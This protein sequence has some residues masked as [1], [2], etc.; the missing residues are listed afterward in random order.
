MKEVKKSFLQLDQI[1]LIIPS[2]LVL[3]ASQPR[4]FKNFFKYYFLLF[5]K[6]DLKS[7]YF[8]P[9]SSPIICLFCQLSA[10]TTMLQCLIVLLPAF[11]MGP[12]SPSILTTPAGSPSLH[13]SLDTTPP[14]PSR[15]QAQG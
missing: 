4:N 7:S 9:R 15:P 13:T 14:S 10:D 2:G 6:S 8:L 3:L 11:S 5:V 12:A 1:P